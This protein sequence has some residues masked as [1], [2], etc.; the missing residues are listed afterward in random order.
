MSMTAT[1]GLRCPYCRA[2]APAGA[3]WCSLCFADLRPADERPGPAPTAPEAAAVETPLD[4]SVPARATG[5]H[6]RPGGP[7]SGGAKASSADHLAEQLAEQLL[8]ELAASESGAPLGRLSG[9]V[10]TTGKKVTVMVGGAVLAMGALFVLMWV[11][12][13]LL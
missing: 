8:A 5:R 9:L 10:D 6:A 2:L 11:L 12:G 3:R 7:T 1:P 4:P 13:A